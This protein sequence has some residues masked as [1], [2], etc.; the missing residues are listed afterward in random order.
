[1]RAARLLDKYGIDYNILTVITPDVVRHIDSI[2]SFYQKNHFRYLQF[3]PC[4]EDFEPDTSAI[5]TSLTPDMFEL[6][7]K[8]LFDYWYEAIQQGN[9]I[10]IRYFDSLLFWVIGQN[11]PD[12]G[13]NGSC[14]N[15]M[16]VKA[17]GSVYPCDFYVLD[18]YCLGNIITDG[19]DCVLQNGCTSAF[20]QNSSETNNEC[21]HCKWFKLCV[22]GCKR[23][24]MDGLSSGLNRYCKAYRGFFE[25]ANN[26]LQMLATRLR[27]QI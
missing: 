20:V 10:Y 4:I 17:D 13:M 19:L 6:F 25:Y 15:Q 8:K 1:M 26:R 12:C 9:H 7:M 23:Y 5:Q 16:V 27:H 24:R 14:A 3:I 22:N 21:V 11:A 18:P 2:Y